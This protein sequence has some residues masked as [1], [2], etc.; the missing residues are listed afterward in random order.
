MAAGYPIAGFGGKKEIMKLI[1]TN[2]VL[3]MG[4]YNSNSL[5]VTAANAAIDEL[6]RNNGEAY[7]R[8]T[9]IGNKLMQGIKEIFLEN[10]IPV[11]VQGFGTFF[12]VF[13]IDKPVISYRDTLNINNT[14]YVKYRLSLLDKGIRTWPTARGLWYI[15]AAHTDED[16]ES[17]LGVM[18]DVTKTLKM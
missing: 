13:F 2:M 15:S 6:S 16:I 3:H 4:T 11:V 14:L 5:C 1:A 7:T 10:D 12:S 8:M 18:R 17:T 9:T